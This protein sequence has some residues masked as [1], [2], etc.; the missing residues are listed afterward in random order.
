MHLRQDYFID[1][2]L[3]SVTAAE[4]KA[5]TLQKEDYFQ[6]QKKRK[7]A[8]QLLITS[9]NDYKE[10][11][12][13]IRIILREDLT[14][15]GKVERIESVVAEDS[16]LTGTEME[17]I[18]NLEEEMTR[19]EKEDFYK[20]WQERCIWLS[21]RIGQVINHLMLNE[22]HSDDNLLK[23]IKHYAKKKGKITSPAKNLLWLPEKEQALIWKFDAKKDDDIFQRKLYKM[24]LFRVIHNGI[25]SGILSFDYSYRFRFVEDYLVPKEEWEANKEQLLADAEMSDLSDY[26]TL[27]AGMES[28]L[29][30]LYH[31]VN[32][33]WGLT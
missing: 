9:R 27:L 7:A 25:K 15:Q 4:N 26:E 8:T 28:N 10:Q 1:I 6:R 13:E 16:S 17:L 29:D 3:N 21:N 31:Q 12:G 5:K 20:I 14:A 18:D 2:I 33:N 22:A 32:D 30:Q 19:D 11:V 23:A 24:L